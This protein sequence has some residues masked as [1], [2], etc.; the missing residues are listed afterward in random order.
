MRGFVLH[1]EFYSPPHS[2]N[3]GIFSFFDFPPGW[4]KDHSRGKHYIFY[5]FTQ[6]S[7]QEKKNFFF[8]FKQVFFF[9]NYYYF[10][11]SQY[12]G[13]G[14]EA[15]QHLGRFGRWNS[16]F[17]FFFFVFFFFFFTSHSIAFFS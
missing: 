1:F 7:S 11:C 17:F 8:P 5:A 14:P 13:V 6:S 4:T 16:F 12:V 2:C 9:F 10:A 3:V 15:C